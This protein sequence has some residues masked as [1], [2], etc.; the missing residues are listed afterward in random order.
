MTKYIQDV[1]KLL[2]ILPKKKKKDYVE[3]MAYVRP[4]M[5][6]GEWD[7]DIGEMIDD[8][9]NDKNI[10][11]MRPHKRPRLQSDHHIPILSWCFPLWS[12]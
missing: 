8:I 1:L 11:A 4:L 12:I 10:G 9:Y 7:W 2:K 3:M 5:T 6:F